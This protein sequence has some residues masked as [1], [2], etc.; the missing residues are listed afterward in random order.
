LVE[1][2]DFVEELG[3]T[4][5]GWEERWWGESFESEYALRKVLREWGVSE[6]AVQADGPCYA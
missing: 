6:L 4:R 5:R 2:E 1:G 3:G